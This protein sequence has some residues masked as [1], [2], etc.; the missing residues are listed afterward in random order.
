M[1]GAAVGGAGIGAVC[2]IYASLNDDTMPSSTF[3]RLVHPGIL[4]AA[5]SYQLLW[6]ADGTVHNHFEDDSGIP[7]ARMVVGGLLVGLGAK[8]GDGCTSGNGIQGLASFSPASLV[9]VVLFM[10][11]G[12]ATAALSGS[13]AHVDASAITEPFSVPLAASAFGSVAAQYIAGNVLGLR[14]ASNLLAGVG[15]GFSLILSSMV[16]PSKVL[17]FLD[18]ANDDRGWD[19]SLG[20]VMGGALAV[21]I[22]AF[23]V[24]NQRRR[25]AKAGGR[26]KSE[27]EIFAERPVDAKVVA[28]GVLFGAGWGCCG[29]CPGPGVVAC[30][31]GSANAALWVGTMFAGRMALDMLR[32]P[33]S[34]KSE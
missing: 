16:K 1:L 21:A 18:V 26:L 23:W 6:G 3:N 27:I 28:G 30:G 29:L 5:F 31:V 15:F 13:S 25:S 11:A 8:L 20:L 14:N 19:P 7:L 9:F 12:A 4:V 10:A 32:A 2:S 17:G 22:P 24:S 34:A 33:P